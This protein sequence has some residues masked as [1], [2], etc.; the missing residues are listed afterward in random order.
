MPIAKI[1]PIRPYA[2]YVSILRKTG[3][4]EY[5]V[6]ILVPIIGNQVITFQES[7]GNESYKIT[8]DVKDGPTAP[9]PERTDSTDPT[10]ST[11]AAGSSSGAMSPARA[12]SSPSTVIPTR[13][14]IHTRIKIDNS[15][16]PNYDPNKFEVICTIENK[17]QSK[18][19]SH[20][21]GIYVRD[22]QEIDDLDI[23][24]MAL[25]YPHLYL[26]RPKA[27]DDN[28]INNKKENLFPRLLIPSKDYQLDQNFELDPQINYGDQGFCESLVILYPR[29]DD[30]K[31]ELKIFAPAKLNKTTFTE[32]GP[33]EGSYGAITIIADD[34]QEAK[35]LKDEYSSFQNHLQMQRMNS[36]KTINNEPKKKKGKIRTRSADSTSG[37]NLFAQIP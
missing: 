16:V 25:E 27:L 8:G 21:I 34:E 33:G 26:T 20:T 5:R 3:T 6:D 23:G 24:E 9:P 17:S 28:N 2:P 1:P 37:G 18:K 13:T 4:E 30:E 11:G 15:G 12:P 19:S 10:D 14:F 35:N 29:P 36:Q 32:R 22:A 7:K 31:G